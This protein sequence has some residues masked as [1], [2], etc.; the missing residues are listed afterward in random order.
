MELKSISVYFIYDCI[1]PSY[2]SGF[3][4]S[5]PVHP[6]V[7]L[8]C[9]GEPIGM[10][11]PVREKYP[12]PRISI[13]TEVWHADIPAHAIY[14]LT[15]PFSTCLQGLRLHI[16]S[17]HCSQFPEPRKQHSAFTFLKTFRVNTPD[18]LDG[19]SDPLPHP[20]R[21]DLRTHASCL[22]C[23]SHF[24]LATPCV[25]SKL[26]IVQARDPVEQL[27]SE[28][29]HISRVFEAFSPSQVLTSATY[30]ENCQWIENGAAAA[31]PSP[32]VIK[33]DR[34]RSQSFACD[35]FK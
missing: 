20:S 25:R 21:H 30:A 33:R 12:W 32:P 16:A 14:E 5:T 15:T 3:E 8:L 19:S 10:G 9:L 31:K 34:S 24:V 22:L 4:M 7:M 28:L 27:Q 13:N 35:W 6:V 2:A 1:S 29:R 11:K 23:P 26:G 18:A 17:Y